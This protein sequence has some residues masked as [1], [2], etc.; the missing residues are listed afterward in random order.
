MLG[1][2]LAET[3]LEQLEGFEAQ[4]LTQLERKE[5]GYELFV[6]LPD[7]LTL[8]NWILSWMGHIEVFEPH[9]LRDDIAKILREGAARYG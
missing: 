1:D 7:S 5:D 8:R 2:H 4:R 9:T 3:N 6:K